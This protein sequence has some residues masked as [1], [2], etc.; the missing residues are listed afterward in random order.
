MKTS[1]AIGASGVK[2]VGEADVLLGEDDELAAF[3]RPAAAQRRDLD[4]EQG[5][6]GD[7]AAVNRVREAALIALGGQGHVADDHVPIGFE[8]DPFAPARTA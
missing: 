8:G 1:T 6:E 5:D 4:V 3:G 7:V 2:R